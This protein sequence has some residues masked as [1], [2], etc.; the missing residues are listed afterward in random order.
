MEYNY[1]YDA[2]SDS[3]SSRNTFARIRKDRKLSGFR[4]EEDDPEDCHFDAEVNSQTSTSPSDRDEENIISA[5]IQRNGAFSKKTRNMKEYISEQKVKNSTVKI[6]NYVLREENSFLR[7]KLRQMKQFLSL[8]RDDPQNTLPFHHPHNQSV[9]PTIAR[10]AFLAERARQK[11]LSMMM[12]GQT[13]TQTEG[14]F[15]HMADNYR[16]YLLVTIFVAIF[17]TVYM[18]CNHQTEQVPNIQQVFG[19]TGTRRLYHGAY[20]SSN[21]FSQNSPSSSSGPG[22]SS[23]SVESTSSDDFDEKPRMTRLLE[24]PESISGKEEVHDQSHLHLL[25]LVCLSY[26]A[27]SYSLISVTLW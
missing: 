27:L 24:Q 5:K 6:S 2:D 23:S 3:E 9:Q 17:M 10:N 7:R 15:N 25:C 12:T 21:F 8:N 11:E 19:N 13:S 1:D 18:I 26:G 20:E 16:R 14:L 22:A 4:R